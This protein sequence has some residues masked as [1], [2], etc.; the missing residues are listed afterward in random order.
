MSGDSHQD[1]IDPSPILTFKPIILAANVKLQRPLSRCGKGPPLL[2]ILPDQGL[3]VPAPKKSLDPEPLQKWAE[4][5]FA[6]VELTIS[7]V[8]SPPDQ[9]VLNARDA[10][11]RGIAAL[12]VLPECTFNDKVG[13]I[14]RH[15]L[16]CS[17][18][19]STLP[20]KSIHMA[21]K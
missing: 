9:D 1:A 17:H 16:R 6:V 20:F 8:A 11:E 2:V 7:K 19:I 10:C 14:G 4:E 21:F 3:R 12:K 13:V 15:G 18:G 5:G